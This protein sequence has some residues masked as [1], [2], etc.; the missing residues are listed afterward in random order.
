MV[1]D[2]PLRA[3]STSAEVAAET[4][5]PLVRWAAQAL[6]P[7]YP[8]QPGAAWRAGGAVAV[9]GPRLFRRDRLVVTGDGADAAELITHTA[10]GLPGAG[11]LC[12][13]ALASDIAARLP[14]FQLV[15]SFGWMELAQ[16]VATE[17]EGVGW[18]PDDARDE[19]AA[20]LH[21]ANPGSYVF[22]DEP[23]AQRWAGVRDPS[24][25]LISVA[26]DAWPAP[27]VGLIAGVATHPDHRGRG[28]STATCA[29]VASH[30]H[31]RHG[32]VAL[33]VDSDNTAALRVYRGLKFAYRSV[34]VL[35]IPA[36]PQ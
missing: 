4:D 2:G 30:L 7:A 21:K 8:Y 36:S 34:S 12:D 22:P 19:V 5:D 26:A 24:G 33:M 14:S 25:E 18:L 11:V 13:A 31:R 35:A 3:L 17:R 29:F 32:T 6:T 23:G 10:Q 20:L 28:W 15:A 1:H 16:P 9:F 27:D